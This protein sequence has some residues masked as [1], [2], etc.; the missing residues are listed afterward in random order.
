MKDY[1]NKLIMYH[2]IHQQYR[3]GISK[4]KISNHLG[5]NRRTV[6]RYLQMSEEEYDIFLAKQRE[7]K[8]EL[9]A[10]EEFIRSK[11]VLYPETSAAQMH[12]WLKEHY[13]CFPKVCPKTVYNF[14]M[15]VRQTHNIP[16]A[17]PMRDF[18][19]IEETPY[20]KQ[21][22]VDFGE[23]KLRNGEGARVKVYFFAMV[24]SRSRHKFIFLSESPFTTD[25]SILA[26][27]KAFD[28]FGGIPQEIVYD[29]D[30]VFMVSENHGDLML[31]DRFKAYVKARQFKYYFCRKADPQTKGKVENVV[32]YVKQNFLYNRP[33]V[34]IQ[35][36]NGEAKAWL[37]RTAN[38]L[39]HNKTRKIPYDEWLIEK[40]SL[41]PYNPIHMAPPSDLYAV[42][43][44]N[45]ILWKG[46][47]YT[48]PLGTYKHKGGQVDVKKMGEDLVISNLKG[49]QICRHT[50]PNQKGQTVGNTDHKRD[51]T[52]RINELKE[53]AIGLFADKQKARK[54][55]DAI[56]NQKPR[57]IRDQLL[58]IQN[59]ISGMNEK[60]ID[61]SLQYCVE[62]GISSASDFKDIIEKFE[63]Q[64]AKNTPTNIQVDLHTNNIELEK[65]S[66]QPDTSKIADYE[67]LMLNT[68]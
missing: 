19:I 3:N 41:Q 35:T 18:E 27:E 1:L 50:I 49:E 56:H 21:A 67:N 6:D 8:K 20:G 47:V 22:Q 5:V 7:R 4:N 12:D 58:L 51:K 9:I 14:V 55:I 17:H 28:F 42:R 11:L 13:S 44:N 39:P 43:K 29:Q 66:M 15:W 64:N 53:Q 61:T 2:E 60:L 68:N 63:K 38:G 26:H 30:K 48:L 34:D 45:T 40:P 62:H 10:Y 31:T 24:L 54:L 65:Q 36:L 33:Y 25:L 16:K 23:T 46:N 57:Y 37:G 59:T 52:A 32:K